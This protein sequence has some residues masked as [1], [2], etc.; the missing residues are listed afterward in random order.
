[1]RS[2]TKIRTPK[3]KFSEKKLEVIPSLPIVQQNSGSQDQADEETPG[4]LLDG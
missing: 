4:N 2:S 1:M 3:F